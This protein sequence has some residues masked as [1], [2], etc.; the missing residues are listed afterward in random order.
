MKLIVVSICA[1]ALAVAACG[2][3]P[4]GPALRATTS[5]AVTAAL[6]ANNVNYMGGV[7]C[8]GNQLPINCIS[9]ATDGRPIT[10]TLSKAGGDCV[11]IVNVGGS[12]ITHGKIP[13]P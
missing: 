9:T 5:L 11:L 13:C 7:T 3:S 12:D 4:A 8:A 2:P 10:G 1:A 6:K